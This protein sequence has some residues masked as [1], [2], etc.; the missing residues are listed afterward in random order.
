[1]LLKN[2]RNWSNT[3]ELLISTT[4]VFKNR[5]EIFNR[6]D[7]VKKAFTMNSKMIIV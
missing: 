3:V 7:L 6:N 2:D 4:T 5:F 1:M